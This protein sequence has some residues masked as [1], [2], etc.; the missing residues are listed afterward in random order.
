MASIRIGIGSE[1]NLKDQKLG[2]GKIIPKQRLDVAGVAK[3][4]RLLK[5]LVFHL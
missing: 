2:L 4:K 5:S 3:G 1:F